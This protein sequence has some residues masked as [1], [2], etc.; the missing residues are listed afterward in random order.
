[1]YYF[2]FVVIV[3]LSWGIGL[4]LFSKAVSDV[5]KGNF[6]MLAVSIA[7]AAGILALVW[8]CF[9]DEFLGALLGL[10][11]AVFQTFDPFGMTQAKADEIGKEYKREKAL[12]EQ[13]EE[14]DREDAI[15]KAQ[16]ERAYREAVNEMKKRESK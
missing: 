13:Q 10:L 8:F 11:A 15:R 2:L 4:V 12:K 7:A 14:Q 6:L 16:N 1:M 9:N 5:K 3:A